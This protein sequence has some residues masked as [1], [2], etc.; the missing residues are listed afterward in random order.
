MRSLPH[1]ANVRWPDQPYNYLRRTFPELS[2]AGLSLLNGLLTY[3]AAQRLTAQQALKHEYL[4]V[5]ADRQCIKQTRVWGFNGKWRA[6]CK[7]KV[8]L[9]HCAAVAQLCL[10]HPN[11]TLGHGNAALLLLSV[12]R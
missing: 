9:P 3:D 12:Q 8:A 5:S 10:H 4:R 1:A 7:V 11:A 2:D 6:V